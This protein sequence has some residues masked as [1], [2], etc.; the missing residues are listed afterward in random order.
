L[1]TRLGIDQIRDRQAGIDGLPGVGFNRQW[2]Q[3]VL[4]ANRH[5]S[6]ELMLDGVLQLCATQNPDVSIGGQTV[7]VAQA[8]SVLTNW[9]RR[10]NVNSVG[11]HVWTEL[12]RRLSGS[13]GAGLPAVTNVLYA[14]PFSAADPVGTP[15]GLNTAN[16]SVVTRTMGELAY[17]V[18]FFA[19][20]NIP[21]DRPWGQ[22]QFDVR[23]GV[24]MPI[25]GGSGVSG[26]YNAITPS[27]LV[28]G[29][30][31]TPSWV[32]PAMYR[33]SLSRAR[34]RTLARS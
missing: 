28:P 26:V 33:Q 13:P 20:N 22:V 10:N 24:R 8:C 6:A 34:G 4:Y 18:K 23:N 15:H 21:L 31:Y 12:W 32:A 16:A 7:N 9:D 14:V 3:D 5:H 30:G 17:T 2:L 19:D 25:H 27:S 11:A 29:V 1:R